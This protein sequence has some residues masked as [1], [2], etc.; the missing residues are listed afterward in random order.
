MT[1]FEKECY[2][3]LKSLKKAAREGSK[4]RITRETV[5]AEAGKK[6]GAIRPI[7]HPELCNAILQAEA[8]RKAGILG[9]KKE[10]LSEYRETVVG[11]KELIEKLEKDNNRLKKMFEKQASVMLNLL[12]ELGDLEDD[13]VMCRED[14]KKANNRINTLMEQIKPRSV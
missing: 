4:N 13:L 7:R 3:V 5:G 1:K 6:P 2:E 14:L 9:V 10:E 12:H 8:D 11:Q